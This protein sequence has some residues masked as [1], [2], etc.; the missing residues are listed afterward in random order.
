MAPFDSEMVEQGN[1]IGRIRMPSVGSAD[2]SAGLARIALIHRDH[3]ELTGPVERLR[4]SF[5]GGIK[6]MPIRYKLKPALDAS[7][8]R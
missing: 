1:M 3:A 4:S 2:G 7:R 6:H 8:P 5:V